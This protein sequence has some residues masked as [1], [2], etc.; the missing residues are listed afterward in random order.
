MLAER[1]EIVLA[2]LVNCSGRKVGQLERPV[3]GAD[4]SRDPEP[5]MLEHPPYLAILALF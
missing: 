1:H 4:Q 2:N 5:E 3:S